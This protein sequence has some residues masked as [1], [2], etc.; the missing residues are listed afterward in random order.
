MA[1]RLEEYSL[2]VGNIYDAAL[3]PKK[4][5]IALTSIVRFM[6]SERGILHT[7]FLSNSEGR[8][9]FAIG[10]E[11]IWLQRYGEHFHKI[12]LWNNLAVERDF[13]YDGKVFLGEEL[14]PTRQL[15]KSPFYSEFLRFSDVVHNCVGVI[16]GSGSSHGPPQPRSV[17]F[18]VEEPKNFAP[19]TNQNWRCWYRTYPRQLAFS[20]A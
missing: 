10:I 19:K 2:V 6:S 12:D 8:V 11:D 15:L 17:V 9:A 3:D 5:P 1:S 4:W 13:A 7:P 18:G 16:F 14:V 20:S